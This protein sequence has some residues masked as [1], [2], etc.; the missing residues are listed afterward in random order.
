METNIQIG[1]ASLRIRHI[2][3][4]PEKPTLVFLHDSLGCIELWR[5]F[6]QRLAEA[7]GCNLFLYDR[8]GYGKSS[9][10]ISTDRPRNYLELEADVLDQLIRATGIRN[11]ILYGHSDGASITLLA[12]A[13]YPWH[14][15]GIITEGPHVFVEDLTQKGVREA[16]KAFQTTRLR[17]RLMQYHG[18]NTDDL[19][20]A[21]VKNW[22]SP[23]YRSWN[24]ESFLPRITC[25]LLIIQGEKDEY[26]TLEQVA[27]IVQSVS[28]S[29]NQFI[30]PSIGHTPHKE[31][32]QATHE[33]A[34]SFINKITTQPRV[35]PNNPALCTESCP[36]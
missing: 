17:E 6:P 2:V 4:D 25:P 19:M 27:R 1:Q 21:F 33:R 22:L 8:Q 24:I 28:V 20:E 15:T 31:A 3:V 23:Q 5:D 7:T 10:F 36:P 35:S 11:L 29:A 18:S 16:W 9:P 14:F 26:G 32:P 30:I 12:A 13:K 34:V